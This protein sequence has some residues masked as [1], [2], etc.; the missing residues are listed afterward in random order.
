MHTQP[1]TGK[2]RHAKDRHSG[3]T[4]PAYAAYWCSCVV[5]RIPEESN[6]QTYSEIVPIRSAGLYM[7]V[8]STVAFDAER[9][10]VMGKPYTIRRVLSAKSS[11]E[12]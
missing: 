3:R 11:A 10:R 12:Y 6:F 9:K 1:L 4:A 7:V 8:L 2:Q 5:V